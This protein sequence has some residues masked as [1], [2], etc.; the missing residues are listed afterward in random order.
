M[1]T[2]AHSTLV[3]VFKNVSDAEAAANELKAKG[4][5]PN[6]IYISSEVAATVVPFREAQLSMKED[7]SA[8]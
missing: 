8:G 3:A 2:T 7:L 5:K 6:E 4:I 1:A